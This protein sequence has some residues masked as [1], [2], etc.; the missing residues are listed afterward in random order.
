MDIKKMTII[1]CSIFLFNG[2]SKDENPD[3]I[4]YEI[5]KKNSLS[6]SEDPKIEKQFIVFK[7]E[8]EWLNFIPQIER[9]NPNQAES[10]K[11]LNFDFTNNDLI[12]VIGEFYNYCCSEISIKRIYEKDNDIV[13]DFEESGPRGFTALS[14]AYLILKIQKTT[15]K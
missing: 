1:L 15:K 7:T 9:V 5:I 12:I 14:Q 4:S 6:Y 8:N 10:L 3:G 11:N 13:V 2:C